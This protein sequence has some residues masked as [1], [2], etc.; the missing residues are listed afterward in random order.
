MKRF[1]NCLFK[2]VFGRTLIIILMV[3]LQIVV[4]FGSLTWLRSGYP[5]I[6]ESMSVLG[7]ILIIYI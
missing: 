3:L 5:C 2:I 1:L 6:W 4:L 7:T